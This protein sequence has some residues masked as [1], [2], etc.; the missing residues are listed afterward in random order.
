VEHT[1]QELHGRFDTAITSTCCDQ[2][3]WKNRV[4]SSVSARCYKG[5]GVTGPRASPAFK[6]NCI[7][8]KR[9]TRDRCF[10]G[11]I[12]QLLLSCFSFFFLIELEEIRS[13]AVFYVDMYLD[14]WFIGIW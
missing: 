12:E 1:L 3:L 6:R 2:G 9:E 14:H 13:Y 11:V 7:G 5:H 8:Y 4:H 10:S